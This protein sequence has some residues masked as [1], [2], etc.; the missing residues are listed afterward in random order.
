MNGHDASPKGHSS[1]PPNANHSASPKQS[2]SGATKTALDGASGLGAQVDDQA[3][4]GMLGTITDAMSPVASKET[5]P[6][7]KSVEILS[8]VAAAEI[9]LSLLETF[10]ND[11]LMKAQNKKTPV[12]GLLAS[13]E[14]I[15]APLASA[16]QHLHLAQM[17]AG[18]EVLDRSQSQHIPMPTAIQQL[19]NEPGMHEVIERVN[20]Q[21]AHFLSNMDGAVDA[22]AELRPFLQ[23]DAGMIVHNLHTLRANVG[24]KPMG[25]DELVRSVELKVSV[26][27]TNLGTG[28]PRQKILE[29][30]LD[31]AFAWNSSVNNF[32]L[33]VRNL[34]NTISHDEF[35][36]AAPGLMATLF[37]EGK[38]LILQAAEFVTGSNIGAKVGFIA[39]EKLLAYQEAL[40]QA[41]VRG[42]K[43]AFISQLQTLESTLSLQGLQDGGGADVGDSVTALDLEFE[44]IGRENPEDEL[45]RGDSVV[46]G[47]QASFLN[48]LRTRA[49][50]CKASVPSA[51]AFTSRFLVDWINASH[52]ERP[53]SALRSP[54]EASTRMDGYVSVDLKLD[55][56]SAAGF[57]IWEPEAA[58]LHCPNSSSVAAQ[59]KV[60]NPDFDV[61]KLDTNI[62][63]NVVLTD[64]AQNAVPD[65]MDGA[66]HKWLVH[67]APGH[68]STDPESTKRKWN[69]MQQTLGT[70]TAKV[71]GRVKDLRG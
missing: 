27:V 16:T 6:T 26:A 5:G 46:V 4:L 1:K 54:F 9:D 10:S 15:K 52:K 29:S 53:N 67:L 47:A 11:V 25:H 22:R 66:W 8:N 31:M 36:Q 61:S 14:R 70:T 2:G 30:V 69:W 71:L 3:P 68:M 51:N 45:K 38:K 49:R 64:A 21:V 42:D 44:R 37:D 7:A 55:Y 65:G 41:R 39:I 58:F 60:A 35:S 48:D 23:G 17:A 34:I 12:E 20:S 43:A 28:T 50:A 19:G 56:S 13:A 24:L 18:R 57:F 63:V 33:G 40:E 32:S 59:L 62:H